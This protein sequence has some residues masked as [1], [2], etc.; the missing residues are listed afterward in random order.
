[1]SGFRILMLKGINAETPDLVG[2]S[3]NL[4]FAGNRGMKSGYIAQ[5]PL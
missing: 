1:M 5:V 2:C 3:L 4:P